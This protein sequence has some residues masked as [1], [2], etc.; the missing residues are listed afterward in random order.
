MTYSF[1]YYFI[2]IFVW[3]IVWD[4]LDLILSYAG[5]SGNLSMLTLLVLLIVFS[6]ILWSKNTSNI[7]QD[8]TQS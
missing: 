5:I 1:F 4:W 8:V 6:Y 2:I 3:V 7:T